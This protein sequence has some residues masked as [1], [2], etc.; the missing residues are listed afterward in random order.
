MLMS[1]ITEENIMDYLMTSDFN[2]GLTPDEFK[3][4]LY[5][6]RYFYRL[7]NGKNETL[8][9]ALNAKLTELQDQKEINDQ[10]LKQAIFDKS[11]IENKYN[12]IKSRKL[13]WRERISGKLIIDNDEI[14]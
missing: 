1:Q 3:F 13:T 14:K 10:K 6:F 11:N 9:I 4:L 12:Q 7:T 5:K 8:K 2:E